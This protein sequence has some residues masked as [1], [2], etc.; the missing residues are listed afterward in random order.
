MTTI[1]FHIMR[2]FLMGTVFLIG[3]LIVFFVVLHYVEFVDDFFDRGASMSQVFLEYYPNFIPDIV[4][5]TSPLAVFLSCVYLTGKLSQQLQLAALQTSGVSLYRLLLPYLVVAV[6]I[7]GFMFWF[8]GWIVPKTNQTVIEFEQKYLKNKQQQLDPSDIHRQNSPESMVS[9]GFYD[10]V[11]QVAHKVSIQHFSDDRHLRARLDAKRMAWV[12]SL[13]IWRLHDITERSFSP[14]GMTQYRKIEDLD[15]TLTIYP[16]DLARTERE[17]ESMTIP[18][19]RNYIDA[20]RRS[21][22]NNTGRTLVGYQSK[23]AYP[24]A[25]LIV[26][27]IGMPL[28]SVRRRGG[29]AVQIGLGLLIAFFYLATMKL[30]EPFG[31]TGELSPTMAAWL[32]H[33]LFALLGLFFIFRARK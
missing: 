2:R 30:V 21:G 20:L 24:L 29:Q 33:V 31:Y 19:A 11:A 23:F 3:C 8:N 9:V 28:A 18:D 4:R 27:L 26:V 15:T 12:D 22:A 7:S 6:F 17:V 1:D 32:P 14:E 5:L 13:G 16:R 10:R 25:N